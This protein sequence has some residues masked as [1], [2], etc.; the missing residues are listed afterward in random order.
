MVGES[1]HVP[2]HPI[3][4]GASLFGAMITTTG[5]SRFGSVLAF[6]PMLGIGNC[7][8][9]ARSCF[10]M[11]C[12]LHY[13]MLGRGLRHPNDLAPEVLVREHPA[14]SLFDTEGSACSVEAKGCACFFF[15]YEW[16]GHIKD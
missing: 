5:S 1:F 6:S 15:Y 8:A 16:E 13:A 12:H 10:M 2:P 3:D 11:L 7:A 4:V 14:R 9:S